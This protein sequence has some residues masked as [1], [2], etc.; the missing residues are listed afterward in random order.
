MERRCLKNPERKGSALF[1][2]PL[3][4]ERLLAARHPFFGRTRIPGWIRFPLEGVVAQSIDAEKRCDRL[5]D[6][7][8]D[9]DERL[10]GGSIRLS[11]L[12]DRLFSSP[13]ITVNQYKRKFDVGYPTARS[14]L[15]KLEA[16]G[17]VHSLDDMEQ[18]TY[19]CLPIY[20]ITYGE[21]ESCG[22]LPAPRG[23]LV[24]T[25]TIDNADFS[26]RRVRSMDKS[27]RFENLPAPS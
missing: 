4:G 19:Y 27:R 9:F 11:K 2:E 1:L 8:K 24:Q 20:R 26:S 6:L 3:S 12:V 17:I 7:H 23:G 18:I 22:F 16:A 13:V 14:D 21:I 5:L 25:S 10:K 15:K